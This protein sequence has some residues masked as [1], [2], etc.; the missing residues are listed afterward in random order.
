[1]KVPDEA[2]VVSGGPERPSNT[3][4]PLLLHPIL[5]CREGPLH[6]VLGSRYSLRFP[7]FGPRRALWVAISPLNQSQKCFAK[8]EHLFWNVCNN[9]MVLWAIF[10]S[11]FDQCKVLKVIQRQPHIQPYEANGEG[12]ALSSFIY[13]IQLSQVSD[14]NELGNSCKKSSC[15]SMQLCPF[16]IFMWAVTPTAAGMIWAVELQEIFLFKV[17]YLVSQKGYIISCGF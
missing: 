16:P 10:L 8:Q 11:H 9:G 17:L 5:S 12:F 7:G 1:M 3:L 4:Q 6:W 2:P 14:R 15:S 13:D